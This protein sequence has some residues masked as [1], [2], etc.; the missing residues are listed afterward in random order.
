MGKRRFIIGVFSAVFFMT[1]DVLAADYG[2][3]QVIVNMPEIVSYYTIPEG[4]EDPL[5][6]ASIG[7]NTLR[8]EETVPFAETGDA[9]EYHV[10]LDISLSVDEADFKKAQEELVRFRNELPPGDRMIL[11]TFG[12]EALTEVLTGDETAETA[13]EMIRNIKRASMNTYLNQAVLETVT[14]IRE[15][16]EEASDSASAR[17]KQSVIVISDGFDDADSS[18]GRYAAVS[19]LQTSGIPVHTIAVNSSMS[20]S[21]EEKKSRRSELSDI[22]NSTGGVPWSVDMGETVS[23]EQAFQNIG[24]PPGQE[25]RALFRARTNKAS[26][27]AERLT[28]RF[29]SG[30]TIERTVLLDRHQKDD[31][32]PTVEAFEQ[33][34]RIRLMYSEPVAGGE[35]TNNYL[36][37]HEG[38]NLAPIQITDVS[39]DPFKPEIELIFEKDPLENGAYE[40]TVKGIRDNSMEENLLEE[41]VL[42]IEIEHGTETDKT[43]PS[44]A[45]LEIYGEN[46]G[47]IIHFSEEV[48]GASDTGNYRV[49]HYTAESVADGKEHETVTVQ[50]ALY[51]AQDSSVTILTG[52]ELQEGY[53]D[54]EIQN[55]TDPVGNRM[56][57]TLLTSEKI[58][59]K[60]KEFS[61][62]VREYVNKWWPAILSAA[63]AVLFI[64]LLGI[65]QKLKRRHA[66]NGSDIDLSGVSQ[67]PPD[68]V[69]IVDD[70]SI[71]RLSVT[72]WMSNGLEQP[73][74]IERTII[75]SII[76]GRLSTAC[77]IICEDPQMSKQH[78]ALSVEEAG[79]FVTDMNSSNGTF[80]NRVKIPSGEKVA[81]KSGDEILAGN[82]RF[83]PEWK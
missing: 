74:S 26:G 6:S 66:G 65:R 9:A 15:A 11:Y 62:R 57:K 28:L 3:D 14:R 20:R 32:A 29:E 42:P 37:K 48:K 18:V 59:E 50:Q 8:I 52:G 60:E 17:T 44:A 54:I 24:N 73:K 36:V 4:D 72:L 58:P 27:D 39:E 2:I 34:G 70:T 46:E 68:R 35:D 23:M 33:D 81:L 43:A 82:I 51:N 61:E 55:I 53:Y 30:K 77:D 63:V 80:V 67:G 71:P 22:A 76:V 41:T 75:G 13:E 56:E 25:Y 19:A 7:S 83:M 79:L 1:C 49:S 47:F 10:L 45:D 12:D 21:D 64:L 40:I 69:H 5:V 16:K 78:F 38:K 31:T